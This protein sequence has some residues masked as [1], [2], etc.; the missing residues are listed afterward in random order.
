VRQSGEDHGKIRLHGLAF[1]AG[2]MVSFWVLSG[3]LLGLRA[4]GEEVGWGFQLQ[5]PR[6]VAVMAMLMVAIGLNLAGV[7]DFGFA[8]TTLAGKA[9]SVALHR[10]CTAAPPLLACQVEHARMH[11]VQSAHQ[12]ATHLRIVNDQQRLAVV[13]E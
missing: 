6:F 13:A 10:H 8:V 7:F 4:G 9:A 2:V 3:L 11:A 1:A 12:R 5:D